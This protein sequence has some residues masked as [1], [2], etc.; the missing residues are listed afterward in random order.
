MLRYARVSR[1]ILIAAATTAY[2]NLP[3]RDARPQLAN[4]LAEVVRLFTHTI[5]G[6]QRELE[7]IGENPGADL[8]RRELDAWFAA[9]ER[10]PSDWVVLYYTG[11]AE[12]VE[13]DALY[14]LTTDFKPF[15]YPST[16]FSLQQLGDIILAPRGRGQTRRVRNLL[17]IVDTC[18]GGQGTA[19]LAAQ[20]ASVFR[21]RSGSAFYL[22]GAALPRQEAQAGALARALIESV[23]ELSQRNVMQPYLYL[24]QIIPAINRRLRVHDA[25]LSSVASM[26]E[27]PR[28]FPNPSFVATDAAAVPAADAQRAIS[29]REFREHWGPRARGVELDSQP[30]FYFVGRKSV[31]ALL[32]QFLSSPADHRARVVTGGAG[33]GKSAILARLVALSRRDYR[34]SVPDD[35]AGGIPAIDIAVHAKGKTLAD[36]ERALADYLGAPAD[37]KA[38]LARLQG[39]ERLVRIIVDALDEAA[40]PLAIAGELLEALA[41]IPAVR[42]TV[43]T[44]A[45]MLHALRGMEVIDIDQPQHASLEDLT[46]YATARLLRS[47]EPKQ[48]TPYAGDEPVARQ[49]AAVVARRAYPNFLVARLIIEHL[50]LLP[51]P[52]N[53]ESASEMAFPTRVGAAFDEYLARFGE[54]EL[55]VRDILRPLAFAEGQGLPWDSI[56]APLAAAISERPYSDDDV[57]WVL[58]HAGAFVL[59]ATEEGR[60]VYRLYHQALADTLRA[61]VASSAIDASFTRVLQEAVPRRAGAAS[62]DWLLASRYAR[63]HVATHAARCGK[64]GDLVQDP[65]Y[66]LAAEPTRLLH[67]IHAHADQVPRATAALYTDVVHHIRNEPLGTAAAYLALGARERGLG[68]IA[69]AISASGLG[70][71]WRVAWARWSPRMPSR[72]LAK[73][74]SEIYALEVAAWGEDRPVALIGRENG[75]VEVW[76]LAQGDALVRWRPPGVESA[77]RVALADAATGAFLVASWNNDKL[78]VYDLRTHNSMVLDVNCV[79]AL[80]VAEHDRE[81]VCFTAHDDMSLVMRS[82][83]KLEPIVAKPLAAKGRIYGLAVLDIGDCSVLASVGDCLQ[84]VENKIDPSTIRIWSLDDLTLLWEDSRGERSVPH[85]IEGARI[86][87]HEVAV[88]SQRHWGPLQIWDFRKGRLLFSD[89]RASNR[90]WLHEHEGESLLIDVGSSDFTARTLTRVE[91]A[92]TTS[93]SALPFGRPV[94]FQGADRSS[95]I[96]RLFGRATILSVVLDHVR[97]WDVSDL[98]AEAKRGD[99]AAQ[100]LERPMVSSLV[101]GADGKLLYA[102]MRDRVVALDAENGAFAWERSLELTSEAGHVVDMALDACGRRLVAV[103]YTSRHTWQGSSL[104]VL[105]LEATSA[106]AGVITRLERTL[107]TRVRLASL[108]GATIAFVA[109]GHDVWSVRVWNVDTGEEIPT[110]HAFSL[111]HGEEDKPLYGLAAAAT[112]RSV[113]LAFASKYSQVMVADFPQSLADD[114]PLWQRYATWPIPFHREQYVHS[115]AMADSDGALTLAAGTE[116]GHVAIWDALNGDSIGMRDDAHLGKIDALAFGHHGAERVLASGGRDGSVRVWSSALEEL[117]RIDIGENVTALTWVGPGR[118]AIGSPQGVL[119]VDFT[120]SCGGTFSPAVARQF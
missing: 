21:Q 27:E 14:L 90:A 77:H 15:L 116:Y 94:P 42:L 58:Q 115:L 8:L 66:L 64:L 100:W 25:V 104:H 33:S 9:D 99:A 79:S 26:R 31:L 2:P 109:C 56:W 102:A 59:E 111:R 50:L 88:V 30:G 62:A 35:A 105:E 36:V 67:E 91:A 68:E 112:G 54:R 10:D 108:G 38:V 53:P 82:L 43:G 61:H 5:G 24:D 45:N 32:S 23:Q 39:R 12:V 18:F 51:R 96:F 34:A 37:L 120:S 40:E 107:V 48:W 87:D 28:F 86:F 17:V 55:L 85:Y 110:H 46:D 93:L 83:P 6:Y 80:C 84:T 73:G 52:V 114:V 71:P 81:S 3:E 74:A 29:D 76:D 49:V 4:V 95:K 22:L 78:G 11:H 106:R 63:S 16:A 75:E 113:R 103:T 1:H 19:E 65:L 44:R 72:L 92:G 69:D 101:A 89:E 47:S 41:A 119:L 57:R 60:S 13:P 117:F 98:L 97:V 118:L 70:E 7:G 20:L